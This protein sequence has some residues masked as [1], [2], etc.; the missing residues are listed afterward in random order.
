ML[1]LKALKKKG[2]VLAGS[3]G[4]RDYGFASLAEVRPAETKPNEGCVLA[5]TNGE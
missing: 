3:N 4:C 5:D 1:N 2:G